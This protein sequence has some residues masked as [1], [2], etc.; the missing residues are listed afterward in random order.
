MLNQLRLLKVF[1]KISG[2][3]LGAFT[4]CVESDPG[5]KTLTI[6]EVVADYVDKLKIPVVYNFRHGHLTDNITVPFGGTIHIN[7]SRS[8]VEIT[9]SVVT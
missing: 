6:G 8:I 1:D 5:K 9:E 7:A 3:I 2:L 4:D